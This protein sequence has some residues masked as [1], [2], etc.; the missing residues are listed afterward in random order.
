M[1]PDDFE[2]RCR[3]MGLNPDDFTE[4][5]CRS[6]GPGG[7]NVNKVSTA[8]EFKHVPSGLVV[9]VQ[10]SR[11]Q[12]QNRRLAR[13]R[14]LDLI[15]EQRR[16]RVLDRQAAQSKARRQKARR[17]YGTKREMVAGKRVRAVIKQNRRRPSED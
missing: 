4:S 5:F 3:R 1:P 12:A 2:Q 15:E 16:R 7:Q 14:L 6:S 10:N 13:E 11:F 9:S 17:S 8:V